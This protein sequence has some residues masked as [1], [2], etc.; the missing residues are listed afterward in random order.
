MKIL[1]QLI[2][3]IILSFIF[4]QNIGSMVAK[5]EI[6]YEPSRDYVDKVSM[7][8]EID[9]CIEICTECVTKTKLKVNYF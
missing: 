9:F 2:T 8:Q 1:Y 7:I 4:I 3:V 5:K 6:K